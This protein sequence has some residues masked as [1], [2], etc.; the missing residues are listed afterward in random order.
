[1]SLHYKDFKRFEKQIILKRIGINGQKKI[2][3][4]KVL[5]IGASGGTGQ[6]GN[7]LEPLDAFILTKQASPF[8]IFFSPFDMWR[9]HLTKRLHDDNQKHVLRKAAGESP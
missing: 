2:L 7:L 1:M 6:P 9:K 3:N 5:I 8:T 4:S